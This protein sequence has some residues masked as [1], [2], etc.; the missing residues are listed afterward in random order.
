MDVVS[1]GKMLSAERAKWY[2]DKLATYTGQMWNS[3]ACNGIPRQLLATVILNELADI[4]SN[5]VWQHKIPFVG[6]S[7]GIAQIQIDTAKE[8]GLVDYPGEKKRSRQQVRERLMIPQY[9]IEAAAR[10]IRR[11]LDKACV[12]HSKPWVRKFSFSLDNMSSLKSP[13][14][15]YNHI[16]GKTQ[17][18]KEQNLA[19]MVAAAYNSP[20]ILVAKLQTSITPKHPKLVYKNGLTHGKNARFIA[21]DLYRFGLFR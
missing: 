17:L 10:E 5:D 14:D 19:E 20:D 12:E 16:A 21:E 4:D 15:I 1:L 18:E 9:A 6:G 7:L 13:E 2:R 8:H 3:A 11:L